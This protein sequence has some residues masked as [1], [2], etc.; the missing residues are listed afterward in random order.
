MI[1]G[2]LR[3]CD[4]PSEGFR[5]GRNTEN[6]PPIPT[7]DFGTQLGVTCDRPE[8]TLDGFTLYTTTLASEARL[9]DMN[10]NP[11][12]RW[13]Q[14]FS[15]VWPNPSHV[16]Y[17]V[18]D[19]QVHWF[20]SHLFSNGDLLAIY[21]A[22]SDTPHGYGLAKF[23]KDSKLIWAY[24][25]N[26]HHDLDVD[27]DGTIYTLVHEIVREKPA[28]LDS[29]HVP[30]LADYLVVLSSDGKEQHKIPL[31]E[32]FRDSKYLLLLGSISNDP[33]R[34]SSKIRP[35]APPST[36][37][38]P[39]TPVKFGSQ[40]DVGGG[41]V[42]ANTRESGDVL[43]ANGVRVLTPSRADKFRL[44]KVGQVL[45]SVRGI[46]TIAM[47]SIPTRSIVW[48][49]QGNWCSQHDP[50]FLDNGHILLYDNAGSHRASR[51]LEYDPL[52][53]SYPWSYS[54]ENS[55]SF[56]AP[57]RGM[58]QHLAN[59]NVLFIDPMG[60]RILEVTQ[61]KQL[62]WEYGCPAEPGEKGGENKPHAI[63]TGAARY[64][65]DQLGFLKGTYRAR[66]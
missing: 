15:K 39:L 58:K 62:V 24:S 49:A 18:A 36:P 48:A 17:P 26:V 32:A 31:L 54:Y 28:G 23:D 35:P 42:S 37:G 9:I 55:A 38:G 57:V 52:F 19:E 11:V 30:Y 59:G 10:G 12:H 66:P 8:K 22:D 60:G 51:V 61:S 43:H 29:L 14:P 46:D 7:S 47:L 53:Q 34:D 65:A 13:H 6:P 50:E 44:F 16:K 33:T 64:S 20:R 41:Q 21:Q 63:L 25:G 2:R 4:I 27:E 1:L 56:I 5:R 45:I 40:R 3:F